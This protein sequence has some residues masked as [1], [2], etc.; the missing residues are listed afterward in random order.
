[1]R[2]MTGIRHRTHTHSATEHMP[3]LRWMIIDFGT[4][5]WSNH[6]HPR[7]A[8]SSAF[9]QTVYKAVLSI[10]GLRGGGTDCPCGFV[11]LASPWRSGFAATSCQTRWKCLPSY[12]SLEI[13]NGFVPILSHGPKRLAFQLSLPFS[14]SRSCRFGPKSWSSELFPDQGPRGLPFIAQTLTVPREGPTPLISQD[15]N[16]GPP[17]ATHFDSARGGSFSGQASPESA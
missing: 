9:D 8:Y 16:Q 17:A 3:S 14:G 5:G 7:R 12:P 4:F 10:S 1:M 13:P 11:N 2:P 15:S 6:L